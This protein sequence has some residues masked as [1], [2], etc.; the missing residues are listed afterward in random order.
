MK[1]QRQ[2]G[3][4]IAAAARPDFFEGVNGMHLTKCETKIK[5]RRISHRGIS[6]LYEAAGR[7]GNASI[8]S[9][10]RRC[11]MNLFLL[12]TRCASRS[13]LM[14]SS[15]QLRACSRSVKKRRPRTGVM[16]RA[17]TATFRTNANDCS[18]ALS[19]MLG[20]RARWVCGHVLGYGRV[21]LAL[22]PECPLRKWNL[23][24]TRRSWLRVRAT[25]LIRFRFLASMKRFKV[26]AQ[27]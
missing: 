2:R 23:S 12:Y 1:G 10:A 9:W 16:R 19:L 22:Q 8:V 4:N 15:R 5:I 14:C 24:M 18:A 17:A 3:T 27:S 6:A 21:P 7:N 11:A 20:N 26:Q 13:S 25:L